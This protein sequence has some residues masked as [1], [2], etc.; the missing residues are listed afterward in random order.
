M[1]AQAQERPDRNT[2]RILVKA[3]RSPWIASEALSDNIVITPEDIV[4]SG[5]TSL[6]DLPQRQRGIE[7]ARNGGPGAHASVF[8]RGID[9]CQNV[10]LVDDARYGMR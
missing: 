8:I 7:A 6:V 1:A 10:V 2:E 9:S 4:R 5:Q 3:S